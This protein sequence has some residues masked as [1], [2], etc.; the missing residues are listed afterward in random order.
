MIGSDWMEHKFTPKTN[1]KLAKL[2]VT[3]VQSSSDL[4]G[5][6][7][8]RVELRGRQR[9]D[10]KVGREALFS[11][12]PPVEEI[13]RR[14]VVAAEDLVRLVEKKGLVHG[15]TEGWKLFPASQRTAR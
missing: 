9:T 11:G 15:A 6:T 4:T 10:V 1:A 12:G 8:F 5:E 2:G 13:E 14:I 7:V 3:L